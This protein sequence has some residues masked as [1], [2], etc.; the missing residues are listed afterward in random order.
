M[1]NIIDNSN[2]NEIWQEALPLLEK[3]LGT[4]TF[5]ACLKS[6][7]PEFFDKNNLKISVANT[8]ARNWLEQRET[9]KLIETTLASLS[10]QKISISFTID[11]DAVP[12]KPQQKL[13]IEKNYPVA[14]Q[15]K[16]TLIHN[17]NLNPK[18]TFATFVVGNNNSLAHAACLAVSEAPAKVYNPL[19]IYGGVGLGKTHL[20]H[21]VGHQ[22]IT[23]R[24]DLNVTYIST[25]TFTNEMIE[26]IQSGKT[27]NFRNRYRT[28]DI[29]L[30]D[31]IQF[32]ISKEGIQEE[33]FHT[34]NDLH[35]ADKQIIITSDRPPKEIPTLQDR[36]K[37][38]FEWGLIADIQA[39]NLETRQAILRRKAELENIHIPNNVIEYIAEI[40][41]SNI[42]EL[43]GVLVRIMAYASL[44]KAK[45]DLPLAKEAIGSLI[46]STDS[47]TITVPIILQKTADYFA[48]PLEDLSSGKR[49]A[50]LARAR[51]IAM[52]LARELTKTSFPEIGKHF[53]GKDHTTVLHAYNKIKE[54]SDPA[55][56]AHINNIKNE[57][58]AV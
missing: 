57:L 10:G 19:F 53:G 2:F 24:P 32:L 8:F 48:V 9:K 54:D 1:V 5:E 43:E 40:I 33:F 46:T 42:R 35:S 13:I 6:S 11:S 12:Q 3:E 41:S 14:G 21:A 55:I 39:P 58:K 44:K 31:D 49:D 56:K 29:L 50:K 25:E 27:K 17:N 28:V 45:I 4:A 23:L 26:A 52:F 16:K 37:S 18:Y 30:I 34:F 15:A 22:A 7:K 20:M 47:D 51:Q 38:R 36:L